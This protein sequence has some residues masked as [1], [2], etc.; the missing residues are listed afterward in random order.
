MLKKPNR[1]IR[2]GILFILKN[3]TNKRKKTKTKMDKPLFYLFIFLVSTL[4]GILAAS[5]LLE[6]NFHSSLNLNLKEKSLSNSS[7]IRL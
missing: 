7:S 1:R 2:R 6:I 5:F 4:S 3:K